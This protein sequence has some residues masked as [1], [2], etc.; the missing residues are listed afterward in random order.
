MSPG[1]AQ[2]LR[3]LSL[4]A[5]LWPSSRA[6]RNPQGVG[7]WGLWTL[8]VTEGSLFGYLLLTYFYL[9]FQTQ[10]DF[11]RALYLVVIVIADHRFADAVV[12]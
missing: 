1:W 5:W 12:I 9:Y 6:P 2:P 3:G 11:R 4:I 10:H 8:I 7:R